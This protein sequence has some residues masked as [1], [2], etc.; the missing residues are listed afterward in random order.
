ME[1][2]EIAVVHHPHPILPGAD[3]QQFQRPWREGA[4]LREVLLGC[5][6]DRHAEIVVA[7]NDRL[8]PVAEWDTCI[9]RAG[10]VIAV[11]AVVS[12]GGG[13][14]NPLS[15]VASIALMAFAPAIGASMLGAMGVDA[16][17]IAFGSLTYGAIATAVVTVAGNA[18]INAVFTPSGQSL[19]RASAAPSASP[20]YS[21]TGGSNASR[22]YEPLPIVFGR[23]RIFPDYGAKPFTD[24]IGNDQY[25]YQI[26]NFG[27]SA[28]DISDIRIGGTPLGGFKGI[29]TYWPGSDGKIAAF[30]GNVDT[31]TGAEIKMGAG[32]VTRTTSPDTVAI[33]VDVE[34]IVVYT[35]QDDGPLPC[36]AI[37]L[38]YYSVAGANDW[39]PMARS[40]ITD[41]NAAYWSLG[42]Y[43]TPYGIVDSPT[44]LN[45]GSFNAWLGG[46]NVPV[47]WVQLTYGDTNP[48]SHTEGAAGSFTPPGGTAQSGVWRWRPYTEILPK[49]GAGNP[50]SGDALLAPAPPYAGATTDYADLTIDHGMAGE[51]KR[52]RIFKAVPKGTYDVRVALQFAGCNG[53]PIYDGNPYGR[54][55][56][57]FSQLRSYQE[58]N[59]SYYGQTRMGLRIKASGQLNGI[60]QQLSALAAAS[61]LVWH[62]DT[63]TWQWEPTSNP[64]WWFIDFARGRYDANGRLLYGCGLADTQIDI[65]ALKVWAQY[66]VDNK[67]SINAVIDQQQSRGDV[68][69]IIAKTGFASV[70]WAS[71]KLGVVW[72]TVNA[73]PVMVFGMGNI[74]QGSFQVDYAGENLADEFIVS[75]VSELHDWQQEQVRVTVPGVVTPVRSTTIELMGCTNALMAGRFANLLAAQQVY[76]RRTV[77]WE[78]DFEGFICQR[79]DVVLLSHDLTQWSYS[80]RIV[81]VDGNA[82]TL[83]RAVPRGAT[84]TLLIIE[85]DGT[86]TAY[87][88]PAGS[89]TSDVLTLTAPPTLQAGYL[90]VDHQWFFAPLATPGK[91]LKIISVQP[92]SASRVRIMATDEQPEFYA[93]WDGDWN[94][95]AANGLLS[96]TVPVITRIDISDQLA[97]LKSGNVGYKVTIS[98]FADSQVDSFSARWRIAGGEWVS[99]DWAAST[100]VVEVTLDGLFEIEARAFRGAFIGDVFYASHTIVIPPL[101][102]VTNLAAT[103]DADNNLILSWSPVSDPRSV[104]YEVRK[105]QTFG[106]AVVI[107][108]SAATSIQTIGNDTYWVRAVANGIYSEPRLEIVTGSRLVANVIATRDERAEGWPGTLSGNLTRYT[109]GPFADRCG[110]CLVVGGRSL[111]STVPLFSALNTVVINSPLGGDGTYEIP[112]ADIV[113]IGVSQKCAVSMDTAFRGENLADRISTI[114][115]ISAMDSFA[116]NYGGYCTAKFQMATAG[117]DGVF[118]GWA[119]FVPGA[120]IARLFK[121]RALIASNNDRVAAILEKF[122]IT[123]DVPDVVQKDTTSILAA[124]TA[125]VYPSAYHNV[126]PNL[127]VTIQNAAAG[128]SVLLSAQSLTGFT[129]RVMNGGVGQARSISWLAQ[130]Y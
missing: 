81:G 120:I 6:I 54:A 41:Y 129:A 11:S 27:V 29:K 3:V 14:S 9:P 88:V 103:Y 82:V 117:D 58:D 119:D 108:R 80:G 128:D 74:A 7:V 114:P 35:S 76:R 21:L 64:A 85:P 84:D 126:I 63:S 83:S 5:E 66:C 102:A 59:A 8:L 17:G 65:D 61:C 33:A 45:G 50:I 111:V 69:Q 112:A 68:L 116:G 4:T 1:M 70:T 31:A 109:V 2:N 75:Y 42:Y 16:A 25:L 18:V 110:G 96:D 87:T 67:L 49:D 43:S 92:Q 72:D 93:A 94:I 121:F 123:I 47:T 98:L 28:L 79:G 34:G 30:P 62:A 100:P 71:G 51:T 115:L 60:V 24:L 12:G 22:P 106:G 124:G 23:H 52:R 53:V 95:P 78:T 55:Q 39:K 91:R 26:F 125:I 118:G 105:G 104:E 107:Q 113:D 122:A 127:Q 44:V 90:P 32:Y 89:G 73:A 48:A 130:G 19:S 99:A 36:N 101:T 56:Y 37:V 15:V 40:T 57:N 86:E 97:L 13:D 77:S 10:D 46:I 20:T 38:C